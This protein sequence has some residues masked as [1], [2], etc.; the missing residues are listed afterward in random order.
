MAIKLGKS[1]FPPGHTAEDFMAFGPPAIK[2]GEFDDCKICDMGCFN[3]SM[4]DSNKYYMAMVTQSKNNKKWYAY[5]EWGRVGNKNPQFQF[6]ECSSES[7]AQREFASQCHSKNDKRGEWVTIAGI[8]TL[9]AKSGKDCYLVRPQATRSTGLPDARTIKYCK[10]VTNTPTKKVSSTKNSKINIDSQTLSLMRDLNVATIQY[11]KG[12]MADASLPTQQAI[13]DARQLLLEAKKRLKIVGDDVNDQVNDKEIMEYTSQLYSRIPK[14]KDRNVA[15]SIWIL[16]KDNISLWEQDLDAFESVLDE[17]EFEVKTDPFGGMNID[18]RWLNSKEEEYIY[19][20]WSVATRNVHYN[21][22]KLTPKNIW[23]VKRHDENPGFSKNIKEIHDLLAGK[24]ISER[25]FHQNKK[26]PD[27]TAEQRKM[28]WE[29]NTNLL[30]HGT[31]SVNTIGILREGLRFPKELVGVHITG[32]MFGPG[33][34]FAD[35]IKKSAGYTSMHGSYWS[36]GGGS[37]KKR[38]AF[39][40]LCDVILGIPHVAPH[41]H[42]YVKPPNDT[43]SVFGKS[44]YSGVQNNEFIIFNKPQYQIRYLVEFVN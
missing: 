21:I 16:S 25:P 43:H 26:R 27:L 20:W 38:G 30:F 42:P 17:N 28:Y 9:R 10:G 15:T 36:S 7:E 34:Y 24:D 22:G 1:E 37:I 35:D 32:S 40:F 4:V 31:R 29:T 19:T 8:R 2:D 14:K 12:S 5:F 33:T 13:N 23:E 6:V 39:M 3:Q 41:S 44:G 11:T 18:M